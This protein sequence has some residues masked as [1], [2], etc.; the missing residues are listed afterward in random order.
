MTSYPGG[1]RYVSTNCVTGKRGYSSRKL[2][3][4]AAAMLRGEKMS[5]YDCTQ[6]NY[7]HVGHLPRAVIRGEQSRDQIT[8]RRR[9]S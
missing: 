7:W 1:V 9:E 6:C 5:P 2:A 4:E 8:N 3:K